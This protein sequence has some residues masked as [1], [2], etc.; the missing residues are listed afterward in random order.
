MAGPSIFFDDGNVRADLTRAGAVRSP[1]RFHRNQRMRHQQ[2]QRRS[3]RS[4]RHISSRKS[5]AS[6]M[7]FVPG[8]SSFLS[9]SIS[10]V[11]K[12]IG[13]LDTFDPLDPRVAEW[14]SKKGRRDLPADSGFRRLRGQGRFRRPPRA[15]HLRPHSCR[16]R[17]RDCARAYSRMAESFSIAPSSTTIISIGAI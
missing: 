10:A 4:R 1:A 2:R 8:V 17:Q 6:P 12:C 15:L 5:A 7:C 13:G 11:P 16:C 14:W 9:P 3:A